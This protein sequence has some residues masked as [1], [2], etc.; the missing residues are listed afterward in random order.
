MAQSQQVAGKPK[1]ARL[2]LIGA[3][4]NRGSDPSKDQRFVNMFPETR[5]VEQLENTKIFLNKRP[6][7]TLHSTFSPGE[8][9]GV[10]NFQ[11]TLYC[12]IG[13]KIYKNGSPPTAIITLTGS[14][15]N[16]AMVNANSSIIGDY[17]FIAD[18]TSAWTIDTAGAITQITDSSL[19]SITVLTGGS[20][21]GSV[22]V[23]HIS[24][25][26]TATAHVTGGVVTSITVDSIG[27]G[28]TTPPTI[29]LDAPVLTFASGAVN[30]STNQITLTNIYSTGTAVVYANG[31]GTSVAP[32]VSGTTYYVIATSGSV[33]SLA[34]SSTNALAGTAIDITGVGTG[35]AHTLTGTSTATAEGILN[36]LPS[37]HTPSSTFID[38]Y[39]VLSKGIDVYTCDLDQPS[40]WSSQNY[41]SAEMF[42]DRVVA[43]ARNNNQVVVFGP[44]SI[45]FFYD[46]ANAAGSPLSRNDSATIQMGTCAPYCIYQNEQY[47]AYIG[48]SDSGGRAVWLIQGFQPK[49]ISDEYIERIIDA[50][51]DMTDCRGFGFRAKGHLFY[52]INLKTSKRTLVY[53][54]DEKLWHEWSSYD[55]GSHDT[56]S[57]DYM[58]DLGDGTPYV[59][60]S[61]NGCVY[62]VDP[63][64]YTDSGDPILVEIVTNKYDMDSYYR[65]FMSSVKLVGDLL[66]TTN[67]VT[68]YWSDNDYQSWSN[69]KTISMDDTFP[70]FQRLG[71][72]RRRAFKFTHSS[73]N[74]LRLESLECVYTEGNS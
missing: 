15:G 60:H 39:I 37:P 51:I 59:L 48:Q 67:A 62:K 28:Y 52:V 22:P 36:S 38:G 26:A 73:N 53:D 31:G 30:I 46:A 49:K 50:E 71:A 47:C 56:F 9:R 69:A 8:A 11:G 58:T 64:A 57:Y 3:Y 14:T 24:G 61:T 68:M 40:Q 18:G 2:P 34:T 41:L 27:T 29:T 33:I 10:I 43:I 74:P 5:K 7:L 12:A 32:L 55:A 21:Y 20:G 63:N 4:T 25:S 13:N 35:S 72:F 16:V 54:I 45:E 17:L 23:V 66:G 42:P 44:S 1:V 19:H 65:K 6:G 70:A